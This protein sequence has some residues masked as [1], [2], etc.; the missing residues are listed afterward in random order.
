MSTDLKEGAE[1]ATVQGKTVKVTLAGGAKIN[2]AKVKKA[3]FPATNGVVHAIDAV[4]I[5]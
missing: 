3:D 1:V 4:L 2:G 5:P